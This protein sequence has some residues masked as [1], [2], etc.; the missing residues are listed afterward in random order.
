MR[1]ETANPDTAEEWQRGGAYDYA[2]WAMESKDIASNFVYEG[3]KES[4]W[5]GEKYRQEAFRIAERR[6][7]WSGFRLARLL[8]EVW[9]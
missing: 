2:G 4:E 9:R 1:A 6:I 5:P 3:L 8:N 7:A